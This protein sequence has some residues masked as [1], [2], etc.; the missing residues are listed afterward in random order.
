[1][2]QAEVAELLGVKAQQYSR[3]EL[4]KREIPLHHLIT[5]ADFYK[6]SLDYLVGRSNK[7]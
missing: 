5:L 4:G 6:T 1:M 7:K 2:T 3:Y